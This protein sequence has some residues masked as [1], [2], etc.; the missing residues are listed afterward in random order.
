MVRER[1]IHILKN[2]NIKHTQQT[3]N[4]YI[5]IFYCPR[6]DFRRVINELQNN[7]IDNQFL[8]L[9]SNGMNVEYDKVKEYYKRMNYDVQYSFRLSDNESQELKLLQTNNKFLFNSE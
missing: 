1:L 8:E 9:E 6:N 4:E 2:E 5:N 7:C 3:L